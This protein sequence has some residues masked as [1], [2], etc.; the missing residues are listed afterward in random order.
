MISFI[1]L[2]SPYSSV[3]YAHL[4]NGLG[5]DMPRLPPLMDRVFEIFVTSV[6]SSKTQ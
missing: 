4:G 1:G 2:P 5:Y 6:Y 3:R